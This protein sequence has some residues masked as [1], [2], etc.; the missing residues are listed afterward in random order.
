MQHAT[1]VSSNGYTDCS[2]TALE[3]LAEH[4]LTVHDHAACDARELKRI[5][6]TTALED[7]TE[8]GL[9]LRERHAHIGVL[10]GLCVR[11][12]TR[13]LVNFVR[14]SIKFTRV[15]FT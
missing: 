14:V 7:F 1:R 4:G 8:H 15:Y 6:S 2:T 11:G 12:M 13:G 3:D 10:H 9:D 5:Y